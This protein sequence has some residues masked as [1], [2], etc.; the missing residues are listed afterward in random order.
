MDDADNVYDEIPA[1]LWDTIFKFCLYDI[2][3]DTIYHIDN[4]AICDFYRDNI[5]V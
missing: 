1:D 4:C 2:T 3:Y 5:C